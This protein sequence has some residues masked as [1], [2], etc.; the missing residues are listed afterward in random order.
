MFRARGSLLP[1][2]S[3]IERRFKLIALSLK[4]R[5]HLFQTQQMDTLGAVGEDDL[6]VVFGCLLLLG[7]PFVSELAE[8]NTSLWII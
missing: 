6:C 5:D 3:S 7:R 2:T 1:R 4:H 8:E